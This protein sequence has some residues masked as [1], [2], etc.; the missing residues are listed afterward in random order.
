M[1]LMNVK[2]LFRF[3][4]P[5]RS[6]TH[7]FDRPFVDLFST[8]L[9]KPYFVISFRTVPSTC[10]QRELISSESLQVYVQSRNHSNLPN[11]RWLSVDLQIICD[12]G[13]MSSESLYLHMGQGPC[14]SLVP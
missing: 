6:L 8:V 3:Q 2:Q 1:L 11:D 14:I 5:I 10:S 13:P 12:R 7:E 9:F 4:T